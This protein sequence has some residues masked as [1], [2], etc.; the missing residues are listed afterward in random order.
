MMVTAARRVRPVGGH[1]RAHQCRHDEQHVP[2]AEIEGT[3]RTVSESTRTKVQDNIRRAAEGIA[4]AHGPTT[5]EIIANIR[6]RRTESF[7]DFSLGV[8]GR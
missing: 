8:A 7:A 1:R 3:I 2:T 4:A 5:V 6:S